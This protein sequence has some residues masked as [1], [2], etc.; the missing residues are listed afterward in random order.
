MT[1]SEVSKSSL[2]ESDSAEY[3]STVQKK[4]K[5]LYSHNTM[6]WLSHAI[7]QIIL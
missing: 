6:N 4:T 2:G 5:A 7:C 3:H 1:F